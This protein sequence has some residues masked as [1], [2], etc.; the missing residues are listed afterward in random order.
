MSARPRRVLGKRKHSLTK[1]KRPAR[2]N[3]LSSKYP[4]RRKRRDRTKRTTQIVQ[5]HPVR[6][7]EPVQKCP[8]TKEE[9]AMHIGRGLPCVNLAQQQFLGVLHDSVS[10]LVYKLA[11]KYAPTCPHADIEDMVNDCWYRILYRLCT[12][13]SKK[14]KFTTW[15]WRVCAS[16]LNKGYWRGKRYS[17]H[18]TELKDG[19]DEERLADENTRSRADRVDVRAAIADLLLAHPDKRDIIE[20]MFIDADGDLNTNIVFRDV[21]ERSGSTSTKVSRFYRKVVQPFFIERFKGEGD[22]RD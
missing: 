11:V 8:V 9:I 14:S 20:A 19:L 4:S 7:D 17:S 3:L 22:E 21:A 15:C 2:R 13:D 16:V 12:Y 6:F 5:K 18:M 1:K 10:N